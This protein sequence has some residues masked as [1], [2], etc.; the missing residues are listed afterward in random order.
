LHTRYQVDTNG[1]NA[2]T[3]IDRESCEFPDA[4]TF[5]PG[6]SQHLHGVSSVPVCVWF[7]T[8]VC[9]CGISSVPVCVWFQTYLCVCG[10]S[11]VPV[12]EL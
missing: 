3:F 2:V 8:Y 12:C 1:T 9:V 5:I 11:T 6:D 4:T 10:I 7:Q